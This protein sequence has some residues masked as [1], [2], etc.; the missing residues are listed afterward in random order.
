LKSDIQQE[1]FFTRKLDLNL[2]NKL[3]K[4]YIGRW[5]NLGTLKNR[6]EIPYVVLEKQ[7][8]DQLGRSCEKLRSVTYSQGRKEHPSYNEMKEC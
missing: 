8:E 2:R 1:E 7:E 5:K 6:S 4:C 3:V